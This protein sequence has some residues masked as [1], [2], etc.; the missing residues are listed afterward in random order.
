MTSPPP[1]RNRRSPTGGDVPTGCVGIQ[2]IIKH[3]Q[4]FPKCNEVVV[5]RDAI[6]RPD[7]WIGRAYYLY[8]GG[9]PYYDAIFSLIIIDSYLTMLPYLALL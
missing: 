3:N 5:K 8:N 9:V 2:S 4:A 6:F 7:F 1:E